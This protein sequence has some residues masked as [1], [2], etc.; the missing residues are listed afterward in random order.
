MVAN[1][2]NTLVLTIIKPEAMKVRH[3]TCYMTQ[4]HIVWSYYNLMEPDL[5]LH[6]EKAGD[7]VIG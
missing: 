5:N 7:F 6:G 2:A 3:N 4:V 1:F